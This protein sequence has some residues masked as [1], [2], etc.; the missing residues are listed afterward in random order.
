VFPPT[1]SFGS[2]SPVNITGTTAG[3]ATL[4]VS[5]TAPSSAVLAPPK[6]PGVPWFATVCTTLACL[7]FVGIPA[8]RRSWRNI[9][10]LFV[11]LAFLTGGVLSCGGGGSGGGGGGG[12]IAGTTA[13]TYTVTITATSGTT[14][15]TGTVALTVQ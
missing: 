7:L 11:L 5:T 13:G 12:G 6:R 3:S 14:T 4:V 9:L 15:A 1:L 10:S 2:T 8:R